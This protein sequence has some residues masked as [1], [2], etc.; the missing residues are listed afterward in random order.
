MEAKAHWENIFTT[1]DSQ[2]V[3]WYQPHLQTSLRLI[4][5]AVSRGAYIID[6]GGGTST[7][8]DD[9]L[10]GGFQPTVLDISGVALKQARERLG[11]LADQVNWIEADITQVTLPPDAYD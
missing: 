7:L 6:V 8:V 10:A 2:Q 4:E 5:Q 11:A 9:L 3:S 1:K